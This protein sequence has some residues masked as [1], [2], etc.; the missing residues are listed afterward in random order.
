MNLF[1]WLALLGIVLTHFLQAGLCSG[2]LLTL[3]KDTILELHELKGSLPAI[4]QRVDVY[5]TFENTGLAAEYHIGRG[6]ILLATSQRVRIKVVLVYGSWMAPIPESGQTLEVPMLVRLK[7]NGSGVPIHNLTTALD[8]VEEMIQF[9]QWDRAGLL[10]DS[11]AI[12]YPEHPSLWIS[13]ARLC[14]KKEQ[15]LQADSLCSLVLKRER[16]SQTYALRAFARIGLRNYAMASADIDSALLDMQA[17]KNKSSLIQLHKL[18]VQLLDSLQEPERRCEHSNALLTLAGENFA[19]RNYHH[20]YCQHISIP[21]FRFHCYGKVIQ[22]STSRIEFQLE[23]TSKKKY[24]RTKQSQ[25]LKAGK[26]LFP[27]RSLEGKLSYPVCKIFSIKDGRIVLEI[28]YWS[29][30]QGFDPH[31]EPLE[32]DQFYYWFF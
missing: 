32:P 14:L 7:W 15:F 5:T 12:V 16:K 21:V 1:R 6:H 8:Q 20:F 24:R 29:G 23:K 2:T 9:R 17:D 26:I 19:F 22:Y 13:K 28:L 31:P 18:Q 4:G 10:L 3:Q 27:E 25:D 11:L 30:T